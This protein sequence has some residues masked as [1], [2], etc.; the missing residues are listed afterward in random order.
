[1]SA[2]GKIGTGAAGGAVLGGTVGSVIGPEGTIAGAGIGGIL[3]GAY[4]AY[5]A[6]GPQGPGSPDGQIARDGALAAQQYSQYQSGIDAQQTTQYQH[7]QAALNAAQNAYNS[8]Y[9]AQAYGDEFG[10]QLGQ[11]ITNLQAQS[12]GDNATNAVQAARQGLLGSSA[13][14]EHQAG[15]QNQY[16]TGAL[17]ARNAATTGYN[18]ALS[19]DQAAFQ[20][21]QQSI[22]SGN[23]Y[24]SASYGQQAQ[25]ALN[26]ASQYGQYG[27]QVQANNQINQAQGINQSQFYGSGLNAAAGGVNSYFSGQSYAQPGNYGGGGY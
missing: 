8:P 9:R 16:Q 7:Q 15:L 1:M 17:A 14:Y 18:Q 6:Y 23:P 12:K 19:G 25:Q 10:A 22:L 20:A 5:Q 3:G 26:Q 4:G 13:D 11:N 24:A 21:Q 27:Q 2:L